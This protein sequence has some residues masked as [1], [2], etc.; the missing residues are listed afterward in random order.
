MTEWDRLHKQAQIMKE[1]YPAGTRIMLLQMGS[2]PRPVEP[3]TKGTVVAVDDIGT[4]HCDFDNGRGLG[5][6]PGE[7]SF[8]TLTDEELA[9]EQ[10]VDESEAPTMGM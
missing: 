5:I 8:R 1:R 6:V 7:D 9:E 2:D 10:A 3:N 4:I